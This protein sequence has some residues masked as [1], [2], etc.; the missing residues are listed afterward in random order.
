MDDKTMDDS[1]P[2]QFRAATM[3]ETAL[4]HLELQDN[5][6]MRQMGKKQQLKV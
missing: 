5:A 2:S 4:S 3:D 1:F 6:V